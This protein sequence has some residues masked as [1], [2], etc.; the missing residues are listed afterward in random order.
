MSGNVAIRSSASTLPT[1]PSSWVAQCS[2]ASASARWRQAPS[3]W[4]AA[5]EADDRIIYN[6]STG[7]LYF[8]A[9]G[10][11]AGVAVLFAMIAPG[12]ALTSADFIIGG[13]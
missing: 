8:D 2:A 12:L 9:D 11:D 13:P 1:T 3:P 5:A 7:Q 10:N 4:A 6:S